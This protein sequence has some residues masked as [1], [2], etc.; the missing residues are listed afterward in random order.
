MLEVFTA[1]L[2][3][4]AAAIDFILFSAH[5]F[6]C[7]FFRAECSERQPLHSASE[8][9]RA[10]FHLLLNL[11]VPVLKSKSAK[12]IMCLHCNS[13]NGGEFSGDHSW[14]FLSWMH[15]CLFLYY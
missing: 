2:V 12:T 1:A 8:N 10:S 15:A 3:Q 4:T 5:P 9:P 6:L 11:D 14:K 7:T 13:R